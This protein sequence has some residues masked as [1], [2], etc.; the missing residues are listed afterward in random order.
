MPDV[1]H[2]KKGKWGSA[3]NLL[4]RISALVA[5]AVAVLTFGGMTA[6]TASAATSGSASTANVTHAV[7]LTARV[8]AVTPDAE[9][10]IFVAYSKAN[11]TG[12][13][14]NINGCGVHNMPYAVGSYEWIARGQSARMYNVA[15]A[16]GTTVAT[17]GSA[18]SASSSTGVGWKSMF[19]VC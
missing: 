19:I 17:L 2:H 14:T 15:N 13:A 10:S 3:V 12:T 1:L 5:I 8:D 18:T 11:H 16:S 6:A 7:A 4:R 9:T